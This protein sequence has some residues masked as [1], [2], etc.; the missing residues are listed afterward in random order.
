[1]RVGVGRLLATDTGGAF[2][3]AV[4]DPLQCLR[5]AGT[6]TGGAFGAKLAQVALDRDAA[7][8]RLPAQQILAKATQ[9][10]G[11]GGVAGADGAGDIGVVTGV[12]GHRTAA[13]ALDGAKGAGHGAEIAA[14]AER[15]VELH[16]IAGLANCLDRA[17]LD[18]GGIVTVTA[19][20]RHGRLLVSHNG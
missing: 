16:A 14:D 8:P 7:H 9:A 12:H 4:I 1:M 13:A 2:G 5:G 19:L 10:G 6:D 3:V 17:H 15:L 18:A 20:N 11:G